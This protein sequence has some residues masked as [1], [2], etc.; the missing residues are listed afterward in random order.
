MTPR[1]YANVRLKGLAG[2][3]ILSFFLSACA[4]ACTP[5]D[6]ERVKVG[7]PVSV[8]SGFLQNSY[9]DIFIP[10]G[11]GE[12]PLELTRNS[13][14]Y[15]HDYG[16]AR[17]CAYFGYGWT[18]NYGMSVHAMGP[19]D[20]EVVNENGEREKYHWNGHDWEPPKGNF[21]VLNGY[22]GSPMTLKRKNGKLYNF[23][24][25][26]KLTKITDRNG[27]QINITYSNGRP[28]A[29]TDSI[30]RTLT[31]SYNADGL[32]SAITW[33]NGYAT[34]Y[35]YDNLKH[36]TSVTD[37]E[38]NRITYGYSSYDL[39]YGSWGFIFEDYIWQITSAID[40]R[41][42]VASFSYYDENPTSVDYLKCK[43][44]TNA[45]GTS[46]SFSY[47]DTLRHTVVTDE[48]GYSTGY[49]YD[50][51]E[52]VT[53]VTGPLNNQTSYGFDDDFNKTSATDALGHTTTYTYDD[54][55][56]C[57][58]ITD[59]LGRVS[60]FTYE[61]KFNFVKTATDPKNNVTTYF[62]DYEAS[63]TGGG[64]VVEIV[65][66]TVDS[67]TPMEHFVYNQYGQII[68]QTDAKG[69]VTKYEYYPTGYLEKKIVDHGYINATTIFTYDTLGDVTSI[70][71]PLGNMT[72]NQYN[73]IGLLLKTTSPDPFN[74]QTK[75]YYDGNKN[76]VRIERQ[77][78]P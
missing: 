44:V 45:D 35:T 48:R 59:P 76:P 17:Y 51:N 20:V 30:G 40:A 49:D 77:L 66:P 25:A 18:F 74:Y 70:T 31:F 65:Y 50:D 69:T 13:Y 33:P 37:P 54:K 64:N 8:S 71:D 1:S 9:Q 73:K 46:M 29:V 5:T 14:G 53:A 55:G 61:P 15:A 42:N 28:A 4:F 21:S 22:S 47:N 24:G 27:N 23:D 32:I 3:I 60:W 19:T 43:R 41:G 52:N 58:S 16:L 12:L 39:C 36:L 78:A 56:N 62:Y 6:K 34:A 11:R 67:G 7:D 63:G 2:F 10:A 75:Y 72:T 26:G 68:E 57:T 38:G